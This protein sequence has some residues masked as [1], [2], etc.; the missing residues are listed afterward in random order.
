MS[1]VSYSFVVVTNSFKKLLTKMVYFAL[2]I[3]S[4]ID[5]ALSYIGIV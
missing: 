5:V 2:K 4:D 3:L 1:A